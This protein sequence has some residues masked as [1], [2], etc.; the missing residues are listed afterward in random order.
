MIFN[1]HVLC[2][3]SCDIRVQYAC[4]ST[5]DIQCLL[6]RRQARFGAPRGM[7][8]CRREEL[9]QDVAVRR[10]GLLEM[11]ACFSRCA[12]ITHVYHNI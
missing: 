6:C 3:N 4:G 11:A 5:A 7:W 1:M 2:H 8:V 10:S 9:C 12:N